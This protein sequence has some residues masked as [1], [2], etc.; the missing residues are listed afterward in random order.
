MPSVGSVLDGE[1]MSISQRCLFVN[2]KNV[3][4]IL[5]PCQNLSGFLYSDSRKCFVN[6]FENELKIGTSVQVRITGSKYFDQTYKC[7]GSID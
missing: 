3:L 1:V 2:V 7:I 4:K 5:V 6:D